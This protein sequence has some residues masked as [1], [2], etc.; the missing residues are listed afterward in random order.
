M[1]TI[2]GEEWISLG[3]E[4][5][6]AFFTFWLC[7]L[8]ADCFVS[9]LAMVS[10][11]LL[12]KVAG[13]HVVLLACSQM[14][15]DISN[16]VICRWCSTRS[17][18]NGFQFPIYRMRGLDILICIV[19]WTEDQISGSEGPLWPEV[20]LW[21]V[22]GSSESTTKM[23]N[24]GK[25]KSQSSEL[26]LDQPNIEDYLPSGHAIHQEPHG[27]LRLYASSLSWLCC[28]LDADK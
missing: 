14:H 10:F 16:F 25:V 20:C 15:Y 13:L 18:S 22:S 27:R 8:C 11:S 1:N 6:E 23:S 2:F 7:L 24:T 21:E 9:I 28:C 5:W 4:K 3:T 17:C 12:H 19:Y 26:D